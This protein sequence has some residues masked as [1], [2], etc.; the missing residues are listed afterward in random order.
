MSKFDNKRKKTKLFISVFSVVT[1]ILNATL[2]LKAKWG[3]L[4]NF[5]VEFQQRIHRIWV[6]SLFVSSFKFYL[7]RINLQCEMSPRKQP[8]VST[9]CGMRLC[10]IRGC[11]A[12][13]CV[14]PVVC[15]HSSLLSLGSLVCESQLSWLLIRASP[16]NMSACYNACRVAIFYPFC[17]WVLWVARECGN[18]FTAGGT[19]TISLCDGGED[20]DGFTLLMRLI[21]HTHTHTSACSNSREMDWLSRSASLW[22]QALMAITSSTPSVYPSAAARFPFRSLWHNAKI[23]NK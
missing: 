22:H 15:L 9:C 11:G 19:Q 6:G 5:S 16:L 3:S 23:M 14:L 8:S 12:C 7:S 13:H 20:R 4:L 21:T 18:A 10:W 2:K 1:C 17:P